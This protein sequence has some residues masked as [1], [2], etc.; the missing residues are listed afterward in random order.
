[1][2]LSSA[3]QP[4]DKPPTYFLSVKERK[5]EGGKRKGGGVGASVHRYGCVHASRI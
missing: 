2:E 3:L 5:E 4:L 1:M